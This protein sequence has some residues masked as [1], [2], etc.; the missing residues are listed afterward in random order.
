MMAVS[1]EMYYSGPLPPPEYLRQYEQVVPGSGKVLIDILAEQ[2]RHRIA[3]ETLAVTSGI[4]RSWG[5]LIAGF[6]IA[7]FVTGGGMYL[8]FSGHD[9]AGTT[10]ATV[11]V[12]S[13][14]AVFVSGTVLRRNERVEKSEKMR[15]R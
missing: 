1:R 14:V 9:T 13:L 6:I 3:L 11:G 15:R 2:T 4:R 12:A 7:I 10:I 5:G 8:V